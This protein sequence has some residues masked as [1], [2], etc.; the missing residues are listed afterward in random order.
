[1]VYRIASPIIVN[2]KR[3]FRNYHTVKIEPNEKYENMDKTRLMYGEDSILIEG[4]DEYPVNK[5]EEIILKTYQKI[6]P[7]EED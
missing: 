3:K 4:L 7:V 6:I 5:K 2:V 1:V